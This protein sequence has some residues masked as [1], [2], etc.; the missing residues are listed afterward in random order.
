MIPVLGMTVVFGAVV[1]GFA[2][3]GGNLLTLLRPAEIVIICG[4]ALGTV[5]AANP[6]ALLCRTCRSVWL[7]FRGLRAASRSSYLA[8]LVMLHALFV[9]ARRNGLPS[10]EADLDDP[11]RNAIFV[12]YAALIKD[13]DVASFICDTLRMAALGSIPHHDLDRMLEDDIELRRQEVSSRKNSLLALADSL[14]GLGIIAAVLGVILTMGELAGTPATIGK[15]VATALVGT[16]LGI[17]LSY[18]VVTPLAANLEI[19]GE[20]ELQYY[21]TLRAG[22]IAFARGM[23]PLIAVECARR[24]TPPEFRPEFEQ[25]E[26]ACRAAVPLRVAQAA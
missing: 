2:L 17:L 8:T 9:F 10:L 4:A 20:T 15:K 7:L 21:Q 18:G 22:L 11:A 12:K 16:F 5:I 1:W 6:P 23:P 13:P 3:N 26:I 25:M 24:S 14:P 19:M